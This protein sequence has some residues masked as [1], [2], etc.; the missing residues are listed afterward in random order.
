M[1]FLSCMAGKAQRFDEYKARM[2]A[3][4]RSYK[5]DV[6]TKF[7]TYR[8]SINKVFTDYMRDPWTRREIRSE[9]RMPASPEPLEP[10]VRDPDIIPTDDPI[11]YDDVIPFRGLQDR[12][13]PA[14][15]LPEPSWGRE[16]KVSR[17]DFRFYGTACSIPVNE[18]VMF[19]LS[20]TS[21]EC[22]ADAWDYMASHDGVS[23]ASECLCWRE[24]LKL[25]DWGYVRF[26]EDFA[27]ALFPRE[28][29]EESV[30]MQMFILA[31]SGYDLRMAKA[32]DVLVLLFP[33]EYKI[34][35]YRFIQISGIKYYILKDISEC[36]T[37]YVFEKPFPGE[38][39]FSLVMSEIPDLGERLSEQRIF[40]SEK[41]GVECRIAVNLNLIEFYNDYPL[42]DKWDLYSLT[43]LSDLARNQ[44]YPILRQAINGKD[45][46]DAADILLDFVQ[47]AFG[48]KKD[49]EQFGYER[50][51]FVDETLYYPFCDC[52][53]RAILY[54]VLMRELL[55]LET[56]LLHYPGH[57]AT[58]VCFHAEITGDH[59]IL[60]GRKYFVCDPTYIGAGIGEAMPEYK[61]VPAKVLRL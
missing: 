27:D 40:H 5:R 38:Q 22:V 58:A 56:V 18:S 6:Q 26:V 36:E 4:F 12:P 43:S 29:R 39:R 44:L 30:L 51:L 9:H 60:D 21:E 14:V 20:D 1:L 10:I 19:T 32:G 48:Y 3:D 54:S 33:S 42:S 35:G 7:E 16:T 53:D 50:P 59:I 17:I 61:A 52:E 28:Y 37:I 13:K 2:Q 57:L 34:F 49:D 25:C 41:Y 24:R 31:Q 15:P 23:I 46:M 45:E 47:T 8:D 55:G 11:P